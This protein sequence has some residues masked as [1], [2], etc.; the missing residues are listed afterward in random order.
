MFHSGCSNSS[1]LEGKLTGDGGGVAGLLI[2]AVDF[3]V[4]FDLWGSLTWH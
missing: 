2:K 4:E 1:Q 3:V